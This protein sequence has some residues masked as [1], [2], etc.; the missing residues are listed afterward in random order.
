M[1]Q[2]FAI[3]WD[4]VQNKNLQLWFIFNVACKAA[5]SINSNVSEVYLTNDLGFPKENFSIIK[6]VCTPLNIM[7]A[8]VSGYLSSSQPFV[9]QSYNLLALILLSTYSI[10]VLLGTFP[11]ADEISQGTY[12]HVTLVLFLTDLM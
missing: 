2:T 5:S 7:F 12:I 6:V 9:Y 8:F 10:L 1:K 11:A 3:F 4:V